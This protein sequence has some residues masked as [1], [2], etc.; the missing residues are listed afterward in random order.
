MSRTN[1]ERPTKTQLSEENA[2]EATVTEQSPDLELT[3]RVIRSFAVEAG[4]IWPEII[5][6]LA[7]RDGLIGF[8]PR[9]NQQEWREVAIKIQSLI[10]ALGTP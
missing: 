2:I 6:E 10:H 5:G 8:L 3:E 4:P 9:H 1:L 7:T